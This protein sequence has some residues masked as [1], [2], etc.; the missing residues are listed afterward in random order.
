[1]L[2]VLDFPEGHLPIRYFGLPLLSSRLSLSNCQPLLMK[3]DQQ[4]SGWEG[5][6][7]SYAGRAQIIK[8]VLMALS[9]YWASTFILP[10]GVIEQIGKRLC[11]FLWKDR[12]TSGFAKDIYLGGLALLRAVKR[13][14][15]LD[16][17]RSRKLT[18]LEK[19]GPSLHLFTTH[20][21]LSDWRFEQGRSTVQALYTLLEPLGP[22]LLEGLCAS[23]G[24]TEIAYGS[25][26]GWRKM[27][28]GNISST[29]PTV[30]F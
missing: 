5:R 19:D 18:G 1:M 28:E 25:L 17:L 13:N 9:I 12:S 27:G 26:I 3:I 21:G 23:P 10:K 2:V 29:R 11:T 8:S 30:Q 16:Y 15:C 14:I 7:V 22:K 4:I 20:G 6:A 24:L